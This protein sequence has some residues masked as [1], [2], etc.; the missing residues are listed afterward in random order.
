VPVANQSNST[1]SRQVAPSR[2]N[3]WL[4]PLGTVVVLLAAGVVLS[5]LRRDRST[6]LLRA[7]PG[8]LDFGV[9][10]S[11]ESFSWTVPLQN[12]S[13]REL[14]IRD[15]QASCGCGAV[16]TEPPLPCTVPSGASA[17]LKLLLDLTPSPSSPPTRERREIEATFRLEVEHSL[18]VAFTLRGRVR[19]AIAPEAQTIEFGETLSRGVPFASRHVVVRELVPLSQLAAECDPAVG[20]VRVS[21]LA[22][23]HGKH[24]VVFLPNPQLPEGSFA[25][26]IKLTS[27]TVDGEVLPAV[28]IPVAGNVLPEIRCIPPGLDVG[29]HAIGDTVEES[30]VL[31]SSGGRPFEILDTTTAFNDN[32]CD[33]RVVES[34][35]GAGTS[36]RTFVVSVG[37]Q[38]TGH[39]SAKIEFAVRDPDRQ[40]KTIVL[41]VKGYGVQD[42]AAGKQ[43]S[44]HPTLKP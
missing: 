9:V 29:V 17:Q 3:Q 37:L 23:D 12:E 40:T 13:G 34:G 10:W 18:P 6:D 26:V 33:L 19:D 8:A 36:R 20:S 1:T 16:K 11:D 44:A 2:R 4:L 38:K 14:T 24:K 15:V 30:V 32:T 27:T 43:A 42:P 31:Q 41:P 28:S 25:A 39:N 5:T 7:D 35:D 22:E 21:S